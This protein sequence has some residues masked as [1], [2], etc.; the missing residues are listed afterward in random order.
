M[1][2]PRPRAIPTGLLLAAIVLLAF[3]YHAARSR[4]HASPVVF[5]D[6]LLYSKL[7]QSIAAGEGLLVRGEP[8]FFPGFLPA[9]VQAPAWLVESVPSA[10][11]LAKALNA[12]VM[13]AAAVPAYWLARQ[14][15]RPRWALVA[16]AATVAAPA[17]AYHAYLMSEALAYPVFLLAL[18]TMVRALA[19]PS[20]RWELAVV[21][22]SLLAVTT[23]IQFVA[24][25]LA[26]LLAVPLAA[27]LSG[28]SARA[29]LR[30]HAL[31]TGS[32][33]VLGALA[34]LSGGRALGPYLGATLLE[35][36]PAQIARWT[37]LTGALIP[38][39]AGWLVV[40]GAA[41]G[42]TY[43]VA[44]PRGRPE[45]AFA[46]LALAAGGLTLLA[47]GFVAAAEAQRPLERYTIYL[48]PLAFVCLFLYVERAAPLR[49]A[50]VALALSLGSLGLLLPFPSLANFDFSFDSTTLAAYEV[51]AASL[52]LA[53]AAVIFAGLPLAGSLLLAI[54]PLRSRAPL[55]LACGSIALMAMMG[56]GLSSEG[57]DR[58]RQTLDLWA[59]SPP[60]WLDR[61]GL[62]RADY[63]ELPGSSPHVG[64]AFEAWNRGS[65]RFIQ[66]GTPSRGH[67]GFAS[68]RA[69]VDRDGLLL[70]EGEPVRVGVLVVDEV[71]SAI[72][73]EGEVV[74]RPRRG[75]T[76]YR[77]G[78]PVHV[79]SL[80]SGVFFDR[81]AGR[82]VRYQVWPGRRSDRG[83]FRV[84][85][86]I[87]RRLA[88]RNVTLA[89]DG[90]ARRTV[91][92]M[93]GRPVSVELPARGYPVP[94]LRIRTD[95]AEAAGSATFLPTFVAVRIPVLEYLPGKA[96]A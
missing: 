45:A 42:L 91:R 75:L 17:M 92:L 86:H 95:R 11:A 37:A 73:L 56:L 22:V 44:R 84:V 79:R 25:P 12:L 46:V 82:N 87:P 88:A 51:A 39:S 74:A 6:E 57:R 47:T 80:T 94:V 50:Y 10:Y 62:G 7:A 32:L 59:G 9:V 40:P 15:V 89:V 52:S 43:A 55:G 76:A 24:L 81:W 4:G 13:S 31:S 2:E 93:P 85:L 58:A 69:R 8:Y 27:R 53:D 78:G 20:A 54:V 41:L 29:A 96:K 83:R 5:T 36:A 38:F 72:E 49:R 3:V 21:G 66:L 63:L 65:G 34:G 30:R 26:Y 1:A 77:V 64:W 67:G 61:A 18:A 28:G 33:L 71:T 70:V 35:A 14:L 48:V 19:A 16:A 68:L 60:D 23:R 90:G